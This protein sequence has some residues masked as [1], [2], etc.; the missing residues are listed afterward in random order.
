MYRESERKERREDVPPEKKTPSWLTL[1]VL[2]IES[3]PLKLCTNVPFGHAHFLIL[4][5]PAEPDAKLYS[6]G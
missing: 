3:C 4:F 2:M 6:V 5:P 1:I